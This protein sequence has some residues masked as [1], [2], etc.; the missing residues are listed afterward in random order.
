MAQTHSMPMSTFIFCNRHHVP[1]EQVIYCRQKS[2]NLFILYT[3]LFLQQERTTSRK[4]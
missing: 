2:N 3:K 1:I 4:K